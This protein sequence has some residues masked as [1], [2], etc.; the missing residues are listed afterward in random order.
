MTGMKKKKDKKEKACRQLSEQQ[1]RELA[2]YIIN[3]TESAA[4]SAGV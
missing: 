2:H 4:T 1:V 3:E